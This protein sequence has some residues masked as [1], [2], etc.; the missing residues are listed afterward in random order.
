MLRPLRFSLL[1]CLTASAACGE[2]TIGVQVSAIRADPPEIDLSLNPFGTIGRHTIKLQS[3][4]SA[5]LELLGA[6]LVGASDEAPAPADLALSLPEALPRRLA[7]NTSY[8]LELQHLPRDTV[9]DEAR[10]VVSSDDP[11]QPL[12]TLP[13][14]HRAVGS[15]R[16]ALVPDAEAAE[17]EAGTPSGVRTFVAAVR[18]GEVQV[19]LRRVETLHI[20]NL[21]GGTLPLAIEDLRLMGAP[22]T[23]ELAVAPELTPDTSLLAALGTPG[24]RTG[25]SRALRVELAFTPSSASSTLSAALRVESSDPTQPA[26]EIPI[27]GSGPALD[28]PIMRIEPASGLDFGAVQLGQTADRALTIHNDGASPLSLSPLALGTNP[29]GVFSLLQAPAAETIGPGQSRVFNLQFSPSAVGVM[30]GS[31]RIEPSHPSVLPV[32][33]ALRGEGTLEPTCTPS[34]VDPAEPANDACG[35]ALDRGAILLSNNG[36]EARSYSGLHFESE[37]DQDWSRYAIEVAAGCLGVGYQVTARVTPAAGESAEVC[38]ALGA[39]GSPER[40]SC[41]SGTASILLFPGGTVCNAFS[42]QVPLYVQVRRTGG[43]L[44]CE[45]YSVSLTA[46]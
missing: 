40:Q 20:V 38:V 6:T 21:G 25:V 43:T 42:N 17:I 46:Q 2:E 1:F 3:V 34:P 39:C 8:E 16:I 23:L 14:R 9:L 41:S 44:S 28:P 13:I 24:L 22:A 4:G 37:T 31:L 36:T 5:S 29:S 12:L 33:L 26:L 27:S 18:F 30:Q 45:S 19:G 7:P 10:L 35:G 11:A 32:E 15:P